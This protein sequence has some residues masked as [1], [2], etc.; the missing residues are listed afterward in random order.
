MNTQTSTAANTSTLSKVRAG[1]YRGNGWVVRNMTPQAD[2]SGGRNG[3]KYRAIV[4][5]EVWPEST[6]RPG[7]RFPTFAAAKA[8][9]LTHQPTQEG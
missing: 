6:P 4:V 1:L 2:G 7:Q 5:W 8:Y 3:N 9:A